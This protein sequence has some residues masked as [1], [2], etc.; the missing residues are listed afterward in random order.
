MKNN[1]NNIN[2]NIKSN[3]SK[4]VKE[5][6]YNSNKLQNEIELKDQTQNDI[7]DNDEIKIYLKEY[8]EYSKINTFLDVS[9][10]DKTDN[11]KL[12]QEKKEKSNPK[13]EKEN[14]LLVNAKEAN[15]SMEET[16]KEIEKEEIINI[17]FIKK[18]GFRK[19]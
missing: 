12:L 6:I 16:L 7:I 9:Y 10:T 5:I 14:K 3:K 11:E 15:L 13:K 4:N 8:K 1:T 17:Y 19:D 18:K 2:I